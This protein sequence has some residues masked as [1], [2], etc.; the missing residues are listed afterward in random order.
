V[1]HPS[2]IA[3]TTAVL[4]DLL[5]R[6]VTNMD[7]Q[8]ADLEVTTQPPDLAR[9]TITKSQLN[10]FLYQ[11]SINAAWR[12][13]DPPKQVKPGENA[14]PNLALNLHYVLTAYGPGESDP[15]SLGLRAL[16]NAMSVL[17][18]HP[19]L[20]AAAVR[21]V[22]DQK[23]GFQPER[24]RVTPLQLTV[25][26]FSKLW[27]TF[28]TPYRTS[29]LYEVSVVLIDS[30]IAARAALPVLRRGE[31]DRGVFT[32]PGQAPVIRQLNMPA[33]QPAVRLGEDVL[34]SGEG[35]S[36]A[37][38]KARLTRIGTAKTIELPLRSAP[39]G[40]FAVH[41]PRE[42]EDAVLFP[43]WQPGI[44]SLGI[45]VAPSGV[46]KM[47]SNELP[48]ALAP[49]IQLG[50]TMAAAGDISLTVTCSP[51]VDPKQRILL[52]FGDR[53]AP[54]SSATPTTLKF[55]IPAV[56][57][58]TYVVRLRVDGADSIPVILTGTPAMPAFDPAQQVVVT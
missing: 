15:N 25:D 11:T 5:F 21:E 43:Q 46:P 18:D 7:D 24:L 56:A 44:Y 33:S 32:V 49:T 38:A 19:V 22:L 8:L 42:A 6:Q 41:L 57:A 2:V 55:D 12:N 58:G 29:A 51:Q 39:D 45:A 16:G 31:A 37:N 3:A 52:L 20:D 13:L 48:L 50:S 1:S 4:R 9:K 36:L 34:I 30:R 26:E 23:A 54:P 27:G 17:H 14:A 35:I 47:I 28:Q 40:K 53:A 10:L